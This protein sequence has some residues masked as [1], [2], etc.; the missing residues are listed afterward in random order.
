MNSPCAARRG[1]F[2]QGLLLAVCGLLW[3]V[4][5]AAATP[6]RELVFL[7]WADYLDPEVAAV[8]ESQCGCRLKL[9]YFETDDARDKLMVDS[10]GAGYDL[11]MLNGLMLHT[12]QRRGWLA[13][14]EPQRVPNLVHLDPKWRNAFDAAADYAVPYFWG[15]LGIAYR[16]DLVPTPITGWHDL[17]Q[18]SAALHGKIAM[19]D[20]ARDLLTAPLKSL[21]A[22]LNSTDP[23]TLQAAKQVLLQQK[24]HVRSY[25]YVA[26]TKDSALLTGE[27]V[28]AMIFNGDALTLQQHNPGIAFVLPRE[29][30]QIWV[31]YLT[32]M[33]RSANPDLAAA[34]IDFLNTPQIAARNAQFVHYAT[35]NLAAERLLPAEFLADPVIYPDAESLARAEYYIR[36]PPRV[37][38]TYSEIFSSVVE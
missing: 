13:R 33:Q 18:P 6:E 12:Y 25:S 21:G 9:V 3:P 31:D 19:I 14:I 10:D 16:K 4:L 8:F 29:G 22:S 11:V 30:G 32:L 23:Q 2:A 27:I 7:T 36:L 38:R 35:P 15:T 5:G 17:M 1:R 26:L 34:F 20:S 37:E 28:A 24:P